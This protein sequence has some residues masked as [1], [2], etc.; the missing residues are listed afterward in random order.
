MHIWSNLVP[1]CISHV[2]SGDP[3]SPYVHTYLDIYHAQRASALAPA[4]DPL[5]LK[6][7]MLGGARALLRRDRTG[8]SDCDGLEVRHA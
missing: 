2:K 4:L 5:L 6:L 1:M 3:I 7:W 8:L